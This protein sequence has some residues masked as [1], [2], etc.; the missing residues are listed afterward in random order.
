MCKA[1]FFLAS[2]FLMS[3]LTVAQPAGFEVGQVLI[4]TTSAVKTDNENS[5]KEMF[6]ESSS[7]WAK[8]QLGIAYGHFVAD[9]GNNDKG[10]MA[11]ASIKT[12]ETRKNFPQGSPFAG[13]KGFTVLTTPSAFTEYHLVGPTTVKVLPVSGILGFH[14]I[15]IKP[16]RADAFEQFVTQKLNPALSQLFPDMQML[17]Y[18]AVA[19]DN[20]GSYITIWT[21]KSVAARDKYWPAG[22]P[23]TSALKAGYAKH[24]ALAKE[25]ETY[26][27]TG[28]YLEPGKGAAAIFESKD[29]T[30]YVLK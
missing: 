30:D 13:S 8:G 16:D 14:Y 15:K 10:H 21:I 24:T 3:F 4:V 18:K 19:G 23:E 28:S 5:F 12:I 26:L 6:K 17:Y 27:V 11:V 7:G 2:F 22:K 9:R 20:V 25:L 1:L 29:W